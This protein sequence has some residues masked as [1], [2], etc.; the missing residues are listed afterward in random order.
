MAESQGKQES[1][2]IYMTELNDWIDMKKREIQEKNFKTPKNGEYVLYKYEDELRDLYIKTHTAIRAYL[3]SK[4]R[5]QGELTTLGWTPIVIEAVTDVF[6][7][8]EMHDTLINRLLTL[9]HEQNRNLAI[10]QK[11][12][13]ELSR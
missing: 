3:N 11:K 13:Q 9:P 10:E 1:E 5:D 4:V 2:D 6:K 8:T 12:E 7:R